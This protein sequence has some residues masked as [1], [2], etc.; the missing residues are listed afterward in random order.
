MRSRYVDAFSR[1]GY[2]FSPGAAAGG[3]GKGS[4]AAAVPPAPALVPR[5]SG[6]SSDVRWSHSRRRSSG[7]S[8]RLRG[9]L[10]LSTFVDLD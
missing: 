10:R 2:G 5:M 7:D 8:A 1:N 4:A 3:G 9:G 6:A